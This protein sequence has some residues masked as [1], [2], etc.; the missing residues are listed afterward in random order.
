MKMRKITALLLVLCMAFS[1]SISAFAAEEH[2]HHEHTVYESAPDEEIA[3]QSASG[4]SETSGTIPGSS[5][6][7]SLDSNGWLT[8]SG[9]GE[10]PVFQSADDQ[11]WATVR[12]EIT[13]VW[14]E[15]MET[16]SISD[17]AYWF[18]GC[19]NLTTAELPLAP[20]IGKHAFYG[21]SK[22]S[23]LTMYYGETVLKSIGEDAFW[24]ETDSG[25]TLY[26]AYLIGYP[27]ATVPFYTYDWAA[28]NRSD[29][30]FYDLYGV[31]SSTPADSG[32]KK[33]P[34]ASVQ[35][36]GTIIGNCPSCGKYAFQGTYVEVAHSSR[37]H[38]NYNECNSCHYVQYLGTYTY[39]SHGAGGYG[40]G[41]CPDCGSH[42]WVLQSQQAATCTSNG[43]RS[44][45]CACG[46][47]KSET[48]YASGHS[49]SYGSWEQYSS[50]QH[51]RTGSCRNCGATDY[52]YA[53]HSMSY[54]SWSNA[55][56]SQHSRT[57]SC[58]T[59]GYSTTE[60]GSHSYSTGT[61]SKYS[62]AQH[63]RSKTCSGCGA[64]TYDYADHSYSYGAWSKVDD[65]QHKR[66][67]TCSACGDSGEEHADHR[68]SNADGICDDC[69]A[70]VSLTI[71]WDAGTNGGSIDGKAS[72]TT[73]G[74]PNTTAT[75][76]TSMPVKT[77]H[78][79]KGWYTSASGGSLYNTVTITAA[80]T[81]YAQFTA[82]SYT[83]TWDLGNGTTEETKQTYGEKL[84]LPT[85][86]TRKNAE[87]L[88]WF[89]EANGGTQVDA[90]TIYKTD[91]DS[92]Y[93]AHWE[94]TEVF[95]VTVPVTLPLIVDEGGEVHV[96]AAEIINASTGDV[97]VSS[98]SISTKNGWQLVPYTTDMAHAKVDA[99]QLGFKI[100]DSVTTKT[101]DAETFSLTSPWK[102]A[103]NGKLP[104]S[105]DAVVSA[106]SQPVTEQNVLSV[107]FVLE[108]KGE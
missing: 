70:T 34:G 85:E 100:N 84:T 14:F 36:T 54:G 10:A 88:G 95:S 32:I 17:L 87:F 58:R 25:D 18:E 5:I 62:D 80:K 3:V 20:V 11:P 40:S 21:C 23:T 55:S 101:G 50:S 33:A 13:E 82:N 30:Y 28:S 64:S 106:V 60:Y 63:R 56:S 41:T 81:F 12:E 44:Y 24:R 89:T 19:T 52:D 76:P 42:T 72:V 96:G 37:G 22:L 99:K 73:T 65:T 61:W 39:K 47:T 105:Y 92:T 27:E 51:R 6:K 38:A 94:I 74:K 104:L 43:Y 79:F 77:G 93:Y 68:D 45:S 8:I 107:I 83:L 97:I 86:P 69:G 71:K 103:E 102:I 108:W 53:S 49:Y 31:Y 1:L 9:S 16:L 4:E 98:V 29:R 91:G 2:D 7:W 48:I 46:Q 75:A 66:T 59:C 15:D 90:N 35:S 26:I 57:A 67:K 78:A